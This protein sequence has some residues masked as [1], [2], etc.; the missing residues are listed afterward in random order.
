MAAPEWYVGYSFIYG[1]TGS[2][3]SFMRFRADSYS[4]EQADVLYNHLADQLVEHANPG[5]TFAHTLPSAALA[6]GESGEQ[7]AGEFLSK[8]VGA[9]TVA[10][11]LVD[12]MLFISSFACDYQN[13]PQMCTRLYADTGSK[14]STAFGISRGPTGIGGMFV[15]RPVWDAST[16]LIY[17]GRTSPTFAVDSVLNYAASG[18]EIF[19]E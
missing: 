7:K 1:E 18:L 4:V 14:D 16:G 3:C 19:R 5:S 6:K 15:R 12:G 2:Y 11:K 17:G 13:Q 10:D 8:G 9:C